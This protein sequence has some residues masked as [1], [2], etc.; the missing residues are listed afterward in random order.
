MLEEIPEFNE[1]HIKQ[2]SLGIYGFKISAK[3]LNSCDM[4][5]F[6]TN[7]Q[8]PNVF[9]VNG[10]KSKYASKSKVR[11]VYFSI[12]KSKNTDSLQNLQ[13]G[14]NC[15]AGLR[16]VGTCAHSLA[17]LKYILLLKKKENIS[18]IS[19]NTQFET[20][21][22]QSLTILQNKKR[23]N[24]NESP[25]PKKKHKSNK[26]TKSQQSSKTSDTILE[27][28]TQ[29]TDTEPDTYTDTDTDTDT[30][31]DNDTEN[32]ETKENT[33]NIE[34]TYYLLQNDTSTLCHCNVC[35]NLL[36]QNEKITEGIQKYL[37]QNKKNTYTD[38][39]LEIKKIY[40]KKINNVKNICRYFKLSTEKQQD[41]RETLYCILNII[42]LSFKELKLATNFQ[43]HVKSKRDKNRWTQPVLYDYLSL[44]AD[45]NN[46]NL[47]NNL[48]SY[49][50]KPHIATDSGASLRYQL[51]DLP[52]I[53]YILLDWRIVDCE[54]PEEI[55]KKIEMLN[56]AKSQ[57]EKDI[58][59]IDTENTIKLKSRKKKSSKLKSTI[60]LKVKIT[61]IESEI[62][63]IDKPLYY[64]KI[65]DP[66]SF[67]EKMTLKSQKMTK[68]YEF[69]A[70]LSHVGFI[71]DS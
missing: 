36:F 54:M 61:K 70:A 11:T 14:C 4:L 44:S 26:T 40:E 29:S 31:T 2:F 9:K 22:L 37:S 55:K 10:I 15:K 63:S 17:V 38:I 34:N 24:I 25:I 12:K 51:I 46:G 64:N 67:T 19:Q 39:L 66:C 27:S 13:I 49:F 7:T 45:C 43:F 21:A 68:S 42:D 35:M 41:A 8:I 47:K 20:N 32:E 71:I 1:N 58:E 53:L 5:T 62:A 52:D 69:R 16:T 23:K 56:H 33:Q 28:E 6:Q 59:N 65:H 30:Y 48:N 57:L 50:N 3:Y 60:G 18:Q